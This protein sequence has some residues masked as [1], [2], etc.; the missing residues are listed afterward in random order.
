MSSH[1][2]WDPSREAFWIPYFGF[3]IYWY[4]IFFAIGFYGALLIARSLVREKTKSHCST[5]QADVFIEKLALYMFVG[6]LLGAR[7][8]HVLL[9]DFTHYFNHPIEIL[10]VRQGGLA[11]HGGVIGAA[12]ALWAF[13]K[14]QRPQSFFPQG[15]DLLDLLA[16]SSAWLAG[17]IRIGNFFNQEIVGRVTSLPWAVIFEHPVEATGGLPRHPVQLYEALVSFTLLIIMLC[18][19]KK[20]RWASQGRLTGYYLLATFSMRYLIEFVK[21]A[22]CSFDTSG[23][24]MGQLLSLPILVAAL[25]LIFRPTRTAK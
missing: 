20:G 16:L 13:I 25:L 23:I 5:E 14:I 17:C 6:T 1:F 4:S 9:Y 15:F 19:G 21:T 10:N 24:S 3:P 22:Q 11:S 18:H 2:S 7:L 8:G 12:L